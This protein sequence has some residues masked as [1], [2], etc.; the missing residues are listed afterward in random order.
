MA[1][2]CVVDGN[3]PSLWWF[4]HKGTLGVI[5]LFD[6]R[7]SIV[8]GMMSGPVSGSSSIRTKDNGRTNERA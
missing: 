1:A 6:A 3:C 7:V 5:V 4:S 8:H 2:G